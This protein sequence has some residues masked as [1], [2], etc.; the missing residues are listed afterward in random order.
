MKIPTL[1]SL[2]L[3]PLFAQTQPFQSM[4][5]DT[6]KVRAIHQYI[7]ETR[8]LSPDTMFTLATEGLDL[9]K[10]LNDSKGLAFM[11]LYQGLSKAYQGKF[12]EAIPFFDTAVIT[13]LSRK[14]TLEAGK[15]LINLGLAY[16]YMGEMDQALVQYERAAV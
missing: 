11:S 8:T 12:S 15:V 10:K 6:A 16:D 4:P 7:K 1:I 3:F 13:H 2:V 14:D 5:D 9:A